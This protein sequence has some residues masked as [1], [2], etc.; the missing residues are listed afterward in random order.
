[1]YGGASPLF[2]AQA[3]GG[4]GDDDQKPSNNKTGG[5][6]DDDSDEDG[7][8]FLQ[9]LTKPAAEQKAQLL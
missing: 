7:E 4:D 1:M 8:A 9:Q 6:F 5:M 2:D 3:L